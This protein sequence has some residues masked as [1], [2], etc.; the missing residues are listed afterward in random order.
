[1][2]KRMLVKVGALLIFAIIGWHLL[3]PPA[4]PQVVG[5]LASGDLSEILRLV[6]QDLRKWVLPKMEWDDV[7]NPRY[8][9]SSVAEYTTRSAS[10]GRKFMLMAKL[11]S[12]LGSV[13]SLYSTRDMS[14]RYGRVR[15]GRLPD[16]LIG[17]LPT[18]R[19]LAFIFR[20]RHNY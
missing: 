6:H 3:S 13:K 11:R 5:S 4:R 9:V 15:I 12:L 18:W 10:S 20:H 2:S 7:Y 8:V 16:M 14:G 19:R 1:M 17:G